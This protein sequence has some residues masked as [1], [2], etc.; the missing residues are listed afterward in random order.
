ML[1]IVLALTW[2]VAVILLVSLISTKLS[3]K[4]THTSILVAV[5]VVA[6]IIGLHICSYGIFGATEYTE[7]E[8]VEEIE[9]ESLSNSTQSAETEII[10][11]SVNSDNVYSYRYQ[12]DYDFP[13]I[14]SKEYK[15]ETLSGSN[16]TE[17]EDKECKN[18]VLKVYRRKGIP[19]IWNM[20]VGNTEI[21]YVFYVPEGSIKKE[22]EL[23]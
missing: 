21:E 7:W 2:N 12:V 16:I 3:R 13:T 20:A 11:V 1:T 10:Y 19:T 15:M 14:N 5:S 9:L 17:F 18:P 4:A 6:I 23:G 22:I 8:N